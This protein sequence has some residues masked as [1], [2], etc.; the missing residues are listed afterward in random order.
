[1]ISV[2][3]PAYN[4]EEHIAYCLQSLVNQKTDT[5]FEVIVVDNAS[6]DHTA[7][8]AEKFKKSLRLQVLSETYKSRGAA[9]AKGFAK[10]KGDIILSTDADAIVPPDWIERFVLELSKSDAAVTGFITWT[11]GPWWIN[12][13]AI[14]LQPVAVCVHRLW[15]GHNWLIGSNFAIWADIYRKSGG[16]TRELEGLEDIDLSTKVVRL[17]RIR[18]VRNPKITASARRFTGGLRKAAWE[19]IKATIEYTVLRKSR[20]ALSDVR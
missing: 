9:R 8:V 18:V 5:L 16:F 11:D 10:A 17:G 4:E 15:I 3:I 14:V 2:V 13:I 20:I 19:Y 7:E 12:T 6:S 1:M